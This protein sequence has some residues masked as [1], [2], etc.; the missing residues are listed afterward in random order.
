MN[1]KIKFAD[2]TYG[3]KNYEDACRHAIQCK[4]CRYYYCADSDGLQCSLCIDDFL[5][6]LC[7]KYDYPWIR[8][9]KSCQKTLKEGR[10]KTFYENNKCD[11][12]DRRC[13]RLYTHILIPS[14]GKMNWLGDIYYPYGRACKHCYDKDC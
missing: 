6:N 9:C 11:F 2:K 5:C 1:K 10:H 4:G 8:F 7:Y 13:S 14:I 3:H 12:C